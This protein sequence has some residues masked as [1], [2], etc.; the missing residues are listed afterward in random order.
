[1]RAS[2]PSSGPETDILPAP[3][4]ARKATAPQSVAEKFASLV[5]LLNEDTD[6]TLS[7]ATSLRASNF[8][9]PA[10]PTKIYYCSRTHSQLTQVMSELKRT[11]FFKNDSSIP[12]HLASSV[13]SRAQLCIN[14]E[15]KQKYS[16]NAAISNACQEL[17]ESE[18]SCP[19][20]NPAKDDAFKDHLIQLQGRKVAD[21]E[22]LLEA[23]QKNSCCAYFSGRYL[24]SP[25][26]LVAVPYNAILQHTT[27]QSLGI[28]LKDSI[29]IF[30][31]AHNIVDFVKQL[32]SVHISEPQKVFAYVH[33]S[34]KT[35]L[36]RYYNRL[37]GA[38]LSA[39]TQ[40]ETFFNLMEL[41]FQ[42]RQSST[43]IW[44]INEFIYFA[45]I[46]SFNF[47]QLSKHIEDTKLFIKVIYT[48]S[49]QS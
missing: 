47:S 20:F 21:I 44:T 31:E 19:Y 1:M 24:L 7:S 25:A 13:A 9:L 38:N 10:Q 6:G 28:E 22:D 18:C 14:R 40:L 48:P 12:L 5:A 34:I 23:G 45:G 15:V 36:E 30:D 4:R 33:Q 46:E 3:K 8:N 17:L 29:V 32:N 11:K 27:R 2:T 39:L 26:D 37:T 41:F 16:S 43:Q 35:Y 49:Y 42:S